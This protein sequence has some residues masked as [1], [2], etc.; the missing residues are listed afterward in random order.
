MICGRSLCISI[1]KHQSVAYTLFMWTV[2]QQWYV[3]SAILPM[4]IANSH[5]NVNHICHKVYYISI[6]LCIVLKCK[7][8]VKSKAYYKNWIEPGVKSICLIN[9]QR[10]ILLKNR[11]HANWISRG[12]SHY[13]ICIKLEQLESLRS[14]D[15]PAAS[16]LPTLLDPKSKK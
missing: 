16:W 11:Y 10:V 4:G 2:F 7:K 1:F 6:Y 5:A 9:Q 15:T 12:Q 8:L 13:L 3:L 14:E